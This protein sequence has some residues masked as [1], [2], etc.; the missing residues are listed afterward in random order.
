M[1]HIFAIYRAYNKGNASH[2]TYCKVE[3]SVVCSNQI[4]ESAACIDPS[5]H[6]LCIV[7]LLLGRAPTGCW[8]LIPATLRRVTGIRNMQKPQIERLDLNVA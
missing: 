8:I 7:R 5:L 2:L 4:G 6:P 3:G 1:L